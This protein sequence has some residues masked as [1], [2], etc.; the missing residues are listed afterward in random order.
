MK[1][2][3]VNKDNWGQSVIFVER[4]QNYKY[5]EQ[6]PPMSAEDYIIMYTNFEN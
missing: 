1:K 4:C 3:T 5:E 6:N 2:I